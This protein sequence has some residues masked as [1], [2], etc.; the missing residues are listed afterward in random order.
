MYRVRWEA[1]TL[2]NHLQ[3]A[4]QN[5]KHVSPDIKNELIECFRDLIA[6]QRVGKVKKS[7]YYSIPADEATDC[8]L[9]EQLAL[10]FRFVDKENNIKEEFVS[11]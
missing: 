1:K 3:N 6:E 9:K 10:I 5:V 2:K 4:P 8:S 11:F 7:R